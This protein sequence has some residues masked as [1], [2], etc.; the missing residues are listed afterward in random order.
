MPG[1]I[2]WS[3]RTGT[4]SPQSPR[5]GTARRVI[6]E[7]R[8]RRGLLVALLA[9]DL[10]GVPLTLLTPVPLKIAVDSVLGSRPL[11]TVLTRAVPQWIVTPRLHPL[12]LVAAL[13]VLIVFAG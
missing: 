5:V 13:E 10:A 4:G 11:P 2:P 8:P 9:V 7:M 12:L 6:G 1:Q 3:T